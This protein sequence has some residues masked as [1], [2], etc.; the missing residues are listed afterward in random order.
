[1]VSYGQLR[2]YLRAQ[3]SPIGD[4]DEMIAAH[5]LALD[6][7]LVTDNVRHFERI[8]GLRIENWLRQGH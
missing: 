4:F 8:P 6:A 5:A 2:A 3:G 7:I 1:M